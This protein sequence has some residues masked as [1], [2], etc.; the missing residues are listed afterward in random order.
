VARTGL[1]GDATGFCGVAMSINSLC[2][3]FE[4]PMQIVRGI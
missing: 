4:T 1:H 2:P 3:M